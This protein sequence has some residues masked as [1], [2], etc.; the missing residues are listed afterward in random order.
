[1]SRA[2]EKQRILDQLGA[3]NPDLADCGISAQQLL[4]WYFEVRLTRPVP[5]D[6][7]GYVSETGFKDVAAFRR[8]ALR[9]YLYRV[10][11]R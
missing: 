11:R 8:A 1:V 9:E 7:D 4:T 2:R 5:A 10:K 3:R 6:L